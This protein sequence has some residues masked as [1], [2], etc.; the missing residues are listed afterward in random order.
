M[1]WRPEPLPPGCPLIPDNGHL[2][3]PYPTYT[4]IPSN[5]KPLRHFAHI[6]MRFAIKK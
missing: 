6:F 1:T 4:M 5:E 3:G 2:K